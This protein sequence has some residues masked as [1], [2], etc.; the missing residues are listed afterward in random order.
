V[1]QQVCTVAQVL[2]EAYAGLISNACVGVHR[3]ISAIL[4]ARNYVVR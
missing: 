1:R 4:M 3:T 2:A